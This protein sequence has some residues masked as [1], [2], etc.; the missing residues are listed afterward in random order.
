[1]D[2]EWAVANGILQPTA[3]GT[4]GEDSVV[5]NVTV[6]IADH[7]DPIVVGADT[8]E[9]VLSH[10]KLMYVRPLKIILSDP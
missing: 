5:R 10:R 1:M 7:L 6:P 3:V 9:E 2:T 4:E 8:T